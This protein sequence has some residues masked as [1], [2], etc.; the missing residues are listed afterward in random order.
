MDE[1]IR[2]INPLKVALEKMSS[3]LDRATSTLRTLYSNGSGGPPGY[4]EVAREE[5][6]E[7]YNRLEKASL[8]QAEDIKVI[9][10]TLL[11]TKD[12]EA[13]RAEMTKKVWK[14]GWKIGAA[15]LAGLASLIGWGWHQTAPVIKILIDDYMKAHPMVMERMKN[16]SH[17]VDPVVSSDQA[18]Q[19][20]GNSPAYTSATNR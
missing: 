7:R 19:D 9:K 12:R 18:P 5:D 14:I 8:S 10:E 13:R 4:L 1:V 6:D 3:V 15:L 2:H 17:E 11:L 20:A 16:L